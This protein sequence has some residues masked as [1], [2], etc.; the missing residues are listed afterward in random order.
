MAEPLFDI[1][2][3][4][5]LMPGVDPAEVKLKLVALFKADA[6]RIE[7]L[8]ATRTFIKKGVDESTARNYQAALAK[9]GAQVEIVPLNVPSAPPVENAA[10]APVM[11]IAEP[12]VLLTEPQAVVAPSFDL[13]ALSLAEVG[14]TLVEPQVQPA[15]QFDLS[16]LQLAPPGTLLDDS[17]PPPPAS[18]D[19]GTLSLAQ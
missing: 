14:V 18:I 11:T 12:G 2:F 19:T 15:P 10:P 6:A 7:A 9:A 1:A 16:G 8:F 13:S 5:Q 17:A 4:G 3:N